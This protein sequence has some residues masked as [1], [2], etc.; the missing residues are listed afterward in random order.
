[1][2]HAQRGDHRRR[3]R[4][5]AL[6]DVPHRPAE[7]GAAPGRRAVAAAGRVRPARWSG[8][9]GP[10]L[11]LHRRR[12]RGPG[13]GAA[14]RA[15]PVT[16]DR[17]AGRPGHRERRRPGLRRCRPRRSRRGAGDRHLGPPDHAGE[18]VRRLGR[19][20]VRRGRGAA[21]IA[22]H[23]RHRADPPAHRSRVR[24]TRRADRRHRRLPG[25]AVP[26]EAGPGNG[27]GVSGDRPVLVELRNVR[28][29]RRHAARRAGRTAAR[30]GRPAAPGRCRGGR[31]R[32][33][34][35]AG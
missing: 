15:G 22:V 20:G 17:R 12:V 30:V 13:P 14:P 16:T 10:H 11:R 5:Q 3:V 7:T 31:A 6:A 33:R 24:R 35:R 28:V 34:R 21:A 2:P 1:M 8:R 23:L 29:A 25:R 27:R 32:A 19:G 9:R 4:Y 26:G 18:G